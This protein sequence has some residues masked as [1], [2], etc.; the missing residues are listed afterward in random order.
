MKMLGIET[1]FAASSSSTVHDLWLRE[2]LCVCNIILQKINGVADSGCQQRADSRA[3]FS[4]SGTGGV[5]ENTERTLSTEAEFIY[6][7]FG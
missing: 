6:I 5:R 2:G 4:S 1:Q 7:Q 3:T